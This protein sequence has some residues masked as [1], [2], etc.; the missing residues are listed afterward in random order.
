MKS[1]AIRI[2]QGGLSMSSVAK[3][4]GVTGQ[5]AARKRSGAA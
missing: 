5:T 4:V 2:Y 3:E 1:K